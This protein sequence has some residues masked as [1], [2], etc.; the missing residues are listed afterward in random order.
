MDLFVPIN[1][2]RKTLLFLSFISASMFIVQKLRFK[3][4]IGQPR[5]FLLFGATTTILCA[6]FSISGLIAHYAGTFKD[7]S[8]L[9]YYLIALATA[10]YSLAN[11]LSYTKSEE[12]EQEV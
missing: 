2:P 7:S 8:F 3:A 4:G 5:A 11:L 12:S 9:V 10:I 1:A 6:T